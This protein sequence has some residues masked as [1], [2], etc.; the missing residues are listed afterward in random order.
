MAADKE[1][2]NIKESIQEVLGSLAIRPRVALG[3][4]SAEHVVGVLKDKHEILRLARVALGVGW[5]WEMAESVTKRDLYDH[6]FPLHDS[7]PKYSLVQHAQQQAAL[8]SVI[9]A[10]Y[11]VTWQSAKFEERGESS[12]G[13][14][15]LPNDISEVS[16]D[17]LVEC[18]EY[19][20]QAV[21]EMKKE[22]QWQRHALNRLLTDF[23]TDDSSVLGMIVPKEYFHDA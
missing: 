5:R 7:G 1:I 2:T 9:S 8:F 14:S 12:V 20:S 16:E 11:Y 3:L 13:R 19:S 17:D 15:P 6:I 18:L 23:R 21:P 4:A 22:V 10:M